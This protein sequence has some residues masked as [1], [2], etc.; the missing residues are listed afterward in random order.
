[1]VLNENEIAIMVKECV[2]RI[3]EAHGAIDDRIK[4]LAESIIKRLRAGEK[5]FTIPKEELMKYYPYRNCPCP[6]GNGRMRFF[7]PSSGLSR[8]DIS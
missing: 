3:L 2:G 8:S 1:M 6:Q 5:N 7:L 4:G